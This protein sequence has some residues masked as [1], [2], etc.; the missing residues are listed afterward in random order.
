MALGLTCQAC[1]AVFAQAEDVRGKKV[2]CPKCAVSLIVTS[3]GVAKR[4]EQP[5][6]APAH[7]AP[8]WRWHPL[9]LLLAV[10]LLLLP[11]CSGLVYLLTRGHIE[12]PKQAEGR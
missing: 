1:A 12:G 9:W 6:S 3:A 2:S 7:L 10:P 4:N 5:Q 8:A 11:V